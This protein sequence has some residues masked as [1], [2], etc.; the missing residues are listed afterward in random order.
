MNLIAKKKE[1][2]NI[3]K[4][5]CHRYSSFAKIWF[6]GVI[7]KL[8]RISILLK[9]PN[10][11]LL[12]VQFLKLKCIENVK[13]T[14]KNVLKSERKKKVSSLKKYRQGPEKKMQ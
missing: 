11:S 2:Q 5:V 1:C 14:I 7:A 10:D 3:R 4:N 8:Y 13:S 12:P 9:L 6:V